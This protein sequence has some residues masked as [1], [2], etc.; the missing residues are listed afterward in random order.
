LYNAHEGVF[1]SLI[2]HAVKD[3]SSFGIKT[4]A[5]DKAFLLLLKKV[6][7]NNPT[8]EHQRLFF[9]HPAIEAIWFTPTGFKTMEDYRAL[10]DSLTPVQIVQ[11]RKHFAKLNLDEQVI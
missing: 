3:L 2:H 8:K 11:L 9:S 4:T 6:F 5:K 10:H 7:G 1:F